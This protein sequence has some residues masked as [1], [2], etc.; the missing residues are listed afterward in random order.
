M[1]VDAALEVEAVGQVQTVVAVYDVV[2]ARVLRINFASASR[3][4]S[5]SL[6]QPQ[7]VKHGLHLSAS[8]G[9]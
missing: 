3:Q 5:I 7:G 9:A 1:H 2:A 8:A 6:L 4:A